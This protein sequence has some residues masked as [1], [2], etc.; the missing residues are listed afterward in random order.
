MHSVEL[1][2][3]AAFVIYGSPEIMGNAIPH[4]THVD[5]EETVITLVSR[6]IYVVAYRF[7]VSPYT[8]S[9]LYLVDELRVARVSKAK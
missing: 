3:S 9:P 2:V 5:Y 7:H 4:S 6:D 1:L 8:H